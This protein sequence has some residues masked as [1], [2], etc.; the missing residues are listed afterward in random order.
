MVSECSTADMYQ[1]LN[2]CEGK[3]VLPGIRP[4]VYFTKKANILTW[5]KLPELEKAAS[6]GALATYVGNFVLAADKK[7]LT[8]NSLEA[9]SNVTSETQ[10]EKPGRTTLNKCTIKHPGVEEDAAGFC[11]QAIADNLIYLIQQRN[12]K[13]RV[14]GCEEFETDTKPSLALGEGITGEAGTTLEVE[15]TDVCPAP[16]YP[17]KIETEDGDISGVDG[18]AWADSTDS[19]TSGG[20][21]TGGSVVDENP[22]G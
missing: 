10:G 18:S 22:L 14:M 6:M 13:F 15:A 11:R 2:W 3:T 4:K 21:S 7:W 16:F 5:P 8:L 1:S 17:G 20:S 12:G 9:K 19:G